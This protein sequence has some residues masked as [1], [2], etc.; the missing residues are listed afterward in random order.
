MFHLSIPPKDPENETLLIKTQ[1]TNIYK[2][3]VISPNTHTHTLQHGPDTLV[4]ER[5]FENH[6]SL[7]PR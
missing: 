1:I 7:S 6:N 3:Q 5:I 2:E 4:G